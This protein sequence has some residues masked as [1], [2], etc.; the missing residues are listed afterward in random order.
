[1]EVRGSQ[2]LL[3]LAERR[4]FCISWHRS[5]LCAW[6]QKSQ[7][8]AY[9]YFDTVRGLTGNLGSLGFVYRLLLRLSK[10]SKLPHT[11]SQRLSGRQSLSLQL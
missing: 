1:L 6:M 8:T 3:K 9:V 4:M 11:G 10:N 5:Y 7:W 2:V